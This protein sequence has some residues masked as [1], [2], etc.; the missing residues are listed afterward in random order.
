MQKI[1]ITLVSVLLILN[2]VAQ[3]KNS[4]SSQQLTFEK[5]GLDKAI[6]KAKANKKLVYL[7]FTDTNCTSCK[8]M[9]KNIFNKNEVFDTYNSSFIN[10]KL[11]DIQSNLSIKKKYKI[12][13]IPTHL[14]IN[15]NGEVVHKAVG[16]YEMHPFVELASTA[17]NPT[18]NLAG[19]RKEF[20][21]NPSKMENNRMYNYLMILYNAGENY[22]NVASCYF[23]NLEERAFYNPEILKS[24]YLLSKSVVS[25]EFRMLTT[26]YQE[27]YFGYEFAEV[28]FHIINLMCQHVIE[29]EKKNPALFY[30]DTLTR[31]CEYLSIPYDEPLASWANILHSKE[32]TH[33]TQ[34]YYEN[35]IAFVNSNF[36]MFPLSK[37]IDLANEIA[38]NSKDSR[39]KEEALRW[40]QISFERNQDPQIL[41][42]MA[43]ALF[44]NNK[45]DEAFGL[46]H[47]A[48]Q[49]AMDRG[50]DLSEQVNM[51][52][53][54]FGLEK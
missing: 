21:T 53:K 40:M 48:E 44:Y 15:G 43:V 39:H 42:S 22:Q 6:A 16:P 8:K 24:V 12:T 5:I 35:L 29:A 2:V 27:V 41:L 30:R 23:A 32:I 9:E 3:Q 51:Y 1:V 17:L 28:K 19:L 18:E 52:K 13:S 31:L 26:K 36:D 11:V 34:G 49:F 37:K 20:N 14:F 45:I 10:I 50:E 46:L 54:R 33:E 47:S 7:Y 25:R 4:T 38:E